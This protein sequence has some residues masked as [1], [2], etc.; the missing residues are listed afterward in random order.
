MNAGAGLKEN[1]SERLSQEEP[2]SL[3]HTE[4]RFDGLRTNSGKQ[5][6]LVVCLDTRRP[7]T[8]CSGVR[9]ALSLHSQLVLCLDGKRLHVWP[10]EAVVLVKTKKIR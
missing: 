6:V 2:S 1:I 10:Q 7:G 5:N 9:I 3:I 4:R 8:W